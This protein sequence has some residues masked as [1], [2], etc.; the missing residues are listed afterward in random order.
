MH[1]LVF[2]SSIALAA[3]LMAYSVYHLGGGTYWVLALASIGFLLAFLDTSMG[4]GYG[5]VGTPV[6]LLL[7]LA[8]KVVVPS[9]LISQFVAAGIGSIK[10]HRFRNMDLTDTKGNDFRLAVLFVAAGVAGAVMGVLAGVRL[11]K[12]YVSTYIGLLV[13]SMGIL[14]LA[15]LRFRF[16]WAKAGVLSLVSSFNKT[17]SG[18]GYGPVL[19]MG[20]IISGN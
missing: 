7:G 11:P 16:T 6:L 17:I 18:G 19:T 15:K 9:I 12:L 4:M 3:V 13:M 10:H 2:G 8:P 5:T 20:Q 1:K 14:A